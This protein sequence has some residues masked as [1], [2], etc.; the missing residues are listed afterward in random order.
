MKLVPAEVLDLAALTT[1]L[2]EGFSGYV[3]PMQLDVDAFGD[4]IA[5]N[6]I[7]LACSRVATDRAPAPS[8]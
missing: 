2:N 4:H 3:V 5:H 6:D 7:D 8:R 1:L